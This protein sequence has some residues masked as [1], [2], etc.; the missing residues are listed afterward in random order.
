MFQPDLMYTPERQ[1]EILA[2]L[3]GEE[4]DNAVR[5]FNC[6]EPC[7]L[8]YDGR[9]WAGKTMIKDERHLLTRKEQKLGHGKTGCLKCRCMAVP[10]T[11]APPPYSS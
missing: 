2:L 1:T 7:L 11:P 4:K 5:C 3:E 10:A 8:A 9:I 6:G